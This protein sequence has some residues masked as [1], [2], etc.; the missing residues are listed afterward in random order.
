MALND[1]ASSADAQRASFLGVVKQGR[2][3]S[4][5]ERHVAFLNQHDGTFADVSALS[6]IDFPDDGRGLALTDWDADGDLDFWFSNRNAPQ[7]RYLEN[8]CPASGRSIALQL[9]GTQCN[10]DAI[11][12][13]VRIQLG[14]DDR[15]LMRTLRAGDGFL[16]QS[17]K[18][19][20]FGLG[21]AETIESV[22]VRWPDGSEERVDGVSSE[23]RYVIT[24]GE[25]RAVRFAGPKAKNEELQFEP[26][27]DPNSPGLLSS[28]SPLPPI[29]YRDRAGEKMELTYQ[30]TRATLLV[31]WASWCPACQKELAN[32]KKHY[33]SLNEKGVRVVT[34]AMDHLSHEASKDADVEAAGFLKRSK[35]P[36]ETGFADRSIPVIMDAIQRHVHDRHVPFQIPFSVLLDDQGRLAGLY[37]GGLNM[38]ILIDHVNGLNLAEEERR[39][40]SVPYPGRWLAP[41]RRLH[42][43]DIILH[44]ARSGEDEL[45]L[46]YYTKHSR[47]MSNHRQSPDLFLLLGQTLENLSRGREA[48]DFYYGVLTHRPNDVKA[49]GRRAILLATLPGKT[50]D[51]VTALQLA[52]RA[53]QASRNEDP[54]ALHA[55]AVALAEQGRFLEAQHSVRAA[56]ELAK[57]QDRGAMV[58]MLRTALAHCEAGKPL[59]GAA[60][61]VSR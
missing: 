36:F 34:L 55:L 58:E 13:R 27:I 35:L 41:V 28:R 2:S 6:G 45:S 23:G 16:S 11:G 1:V 19:L 37:R 25:A 8:Q 21:A 50:Q 5:N 24:Q 3:F 43:I 9:I 14:G 60:A 46:A 30:N 7:I 29:R 32:L 10:R 15:P 52:E 44:L 42:P 18:W 38:G 51:T 47:L 48:L 22:A 12:A 31:L 59:R 26:S 40:A 53:V 4:G 54:E 61:N 33:G 56:L 17:S 49:L 57:S 20:H 39:V